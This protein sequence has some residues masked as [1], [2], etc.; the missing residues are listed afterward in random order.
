M[1]IYRYIKAMKP[2]VVMELGPGSGYLGLLLILD[3]IGYIAFENSQAF[4]LLQNRLWKAAAGQRFVELA[5]D[6]RSLREALALDVPQQVVHVPW[7]KAVDLDL[8]TLPGS[9][10][11]VTANHC[12]AEMQTN[13]MKYYLRLSSML[14]GR[15]N[16]A[17]MFEGWGSEINHPRGEVARE[18][19]AAGYSLCHADDKVTAYLAAGRNETYGS[20]PLPVSGPKKLRN[21]SRRIVG[22]PTLPY[23]Y[24]IEHFEGANRISSAV[25]NTRKTVASE[26]TRRMPDV[27]DFLAACYA[28]SVRSQEE[29]FLDL[30]GQRYL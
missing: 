24:T 14:L 3:G 12:L 26:T 29:L 11:I 15:S 1:N 23:A 5:C 30:I 4:Y 10:D 17:F 7:W 13:A 27:R 18:F 21:L 19:A 20:L 6:S 16:G 9:V 8:R 2:R 25:Q 28:G 22:L